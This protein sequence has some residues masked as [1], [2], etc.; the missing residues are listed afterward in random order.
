[1]TF[2]P[3]RISI[4]DAVLYLALFAYPAVTL[5]VRGGVNTAFAIIALLSI[6]HI[7]KSATPFREMVQDRTTR[8]FAL[9]MASGAIGIAINQIYYQ[10]F[11]PNPFDSELRFLLAILVFIA[12]RN[13]SRRFISVL[14]YAF[15]L[16]VLAALVYTHFIFP[17]QGR[18]HTEFLNAIHVGGIAMVM[19]FLSLYSINWLRKD[20]LPLVALKLAGFAA[21]IY[22]VI[23]SGTRGA[24]LALPIL[25]F[26]W[27]VTLEKRIISIKATA[28]LI[29]VL[30][31][32]SYAFVDV[33]H[34]RVNLALTQLTSY[35]AGEMRSGI[36]DG[37][38]D[39]PPVDCKCT[40]PGEL[41]SGTAARLELWK[42]A[43]HLFK[44][45]PVLGIEPG[46]IDA[47][48]DE[49]GNAGIINDWVVY[50]GKAEMH[51]EIVA[52]V[53]KYGLL[54]LISALAVSLIPAWL[55]LRA[56]TT[57]DRARKAAARMGLSVAVAFLIMGLT[58]ENYNIKMVAAFYS[59]TI[60]I[61]LAVSYPADGRDLKRPSGDL[62]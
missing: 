23:G 1:M 52:R 53:A 25:L 58:L 51:S 18:L 48:L 13:S 7:F 8:L 15:P 45:N 49:L 55:F 10:K 20:P 54:G 6:I 57:A 34:S 35:A 27:L 22:I 38:G 56:L 17:S 33:I 47:K 12:L 32:A 50:V 36:G 2:V 42:A 43:F 37:K 16:G 29:V 39:L 46:S 62:H 5:T 31:L 41:R 26:I 14:E 11:F 30:C 59:L 4:R 40:T 19:G 28:V 21:G 9:A 60:A 44:E 3:G 61:L 24:W